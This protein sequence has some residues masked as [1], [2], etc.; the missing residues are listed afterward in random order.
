[1]PIQHPHFIKMKSKTNANPTRK[2]SP[3]FSSKYSVSQSKDPMR[4]SVG[5]KV[6]HSKTGKKV[7][8]QSIG[9]N[10]NSQPT[11]QMQ[12]RTQVFSQPSSPIKGDP[13]SMD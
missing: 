7:G 8:Q 10:M 1:M 12:G 4:A 5:N 6:G 2:N 9:S 11:S 3:R 13:L